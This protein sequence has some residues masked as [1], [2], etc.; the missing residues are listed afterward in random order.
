MFFMCIIGDRKRTEDSNDE[1]II[2]K[3]IEDEIPKP[4]PIPVFVSV[5][6]DMG[7]G[8]IVK[9]ICAEHALPFCESSCIFHDFN[10]ALRRGA[11][12]DAYLA[13]NMSIY[14]L[15]QIFH[16]FVRDSRQG[17]IENLVGLL[18]QNPKEYAVV[19]YNEGNDIVQTM[20]FPDKEDGN[21]QEKEEQGS[22]GPDGPSAGA[23]DSG[24]TAGEAAREIV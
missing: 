5:G 2:R 3:L 15:C 11:H 4:G 14:H 16:L 20:G 23:A 10:S 1:E 18:E 8:K 6:C 21:E 13:R 7:I 9:T 19:I 12:V 24:N 17:I 22:D